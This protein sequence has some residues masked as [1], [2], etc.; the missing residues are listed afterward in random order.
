M[1]PDFNSYTQKV[2]EL[3]YNEAFFH[4]I[5]FAHSLTLICPRIL[6]PKS[7]A[8][9]SYETSIPT[10]TK[11]WEVQSGDCIPHSQDLHAIVQT[12]EAAFLSGSRSIVL[13]CMVD[14]KL[15]TSFVHMIK[16]SRHRLLCRH[17]NLTAD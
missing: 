14:G 10:S 5:T 17:L 6:A 1:K 13:S 3:C 2:P 16:V 15:E 4:E 11:S 8:A 7:L 12:M 9:W